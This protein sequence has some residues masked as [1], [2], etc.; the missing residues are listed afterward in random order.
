MNR[1]AA[2]VLVLAGAGA[3]AACRNAGTPPAPAGGS[4][5]GSS[6]VAAAGDLPVYRVP[7]DDTPTRGPADALVT[8]V[9][10]GDV[11]C[12]Y[13]RQLDP[14]LKRI[15]REYRGKVRLAWKHRAHPSHLHAAPAAMVAEAA[16]KERGDEA[17]W[18]VIDALLVAEP[19]DAAAVN[20]VGAEV[21][22]DAARLKADPEGRNQLASRIRH[23]HNL[24]FNLG[25]T[26]TPTLFLNGHKLVGARPYEALK[27]AVDEELVRAEALVRS[28]IPEGELYARLVEKG[29]VDP[30]SLE[31]A[32]PPA[33]VAKVP[34]RP[35]GPTRGP[36][37]APVT[38]AVF[39]DFQCPYSAQLVPVIR[40]LQKEYAGRIRVAWKHLPLPFHRNALPAAK[41]AEAARL[42]GKFWE[43]HDKLF[44]DQAALS[45][46]TYARYA[47]ELGLDVAR[48]RRDAAAEA[49]ARRLAEDQRLAESV[50][51]VGTPTIFVNCRKMVG[52]GPIEN[53]RSLVG[54]ELES[55][56][57]LLATGEKAGVGLYDRLCAQNL[58]HPPALPA[59]APAAHAAAK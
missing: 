20:K 7:V 5:S 46:A 26:G 29:I 1:F 6:P 21:G 8:I 49:T 23:D 51:A 50:G 28:G 3:F 35:D 33:L 43:M 52:A 53:L 44:S 32:D 40:R 58:S 2:A 15:E 18:K 56:Q 34:L 59:A 30:V 9:E 39:S 36:A 10:F 13:C 57:G 14:V 22:L 38:V 42:Q 12:P 54:E 17:F 55:A 19:L 48:F 37:S 4:G 45:D 31:P 41:A 11:E 47:R 25:V 24:A 16:R 27:P